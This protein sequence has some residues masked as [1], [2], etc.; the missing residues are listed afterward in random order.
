M[1]EKGIATRTQILHI[2][3]IY[4]VLTNLLGMILEQVCHA[5]LRSKEPSVRWKVV[6][7]DIVAGSLI[8]AAPRGLFV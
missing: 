1:Q 4:E 3:E 5:F 2:H 8:D 6:L 7:S